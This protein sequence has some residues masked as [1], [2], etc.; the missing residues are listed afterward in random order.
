[1]ITKNK[2]EFINANNTNET[3]TISINN[4]Y[5]SACNPRYTLID[6]VHVNLIEF[7][8]GSNGKSQDSIFNDLLLTEGDYNELSS[9]LNNIYKN[10]FNNINEP[11]YLIDKK[12]DPG[13]YVVAEGNRR[14]MCLKLINNDFKLSQDPPTKNESKY[15]NSLT[16]YSNDDDDE[17]DLPHRTLENFKQ[18][19]ELLNSIKEKHDI[20]FKIYYII[21]DDENKL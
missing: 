7:I 10:G 8:N 1:M 2:F 13:N 9:L 20:K 15:S 5:L 11:I 3:N 4:I 12:D 19:K 18:C 21:T 14:I 16:D 6:N 17:I